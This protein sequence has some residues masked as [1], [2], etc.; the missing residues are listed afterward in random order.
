MEKTVFITV[1]EMAGT[2]ILEVSINERV[3]K[4]RRGET[5]EVPEEVAVVIKRSVKA[6]KDLRRRLQSMRITPNNPFG[7]TI[8]V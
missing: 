8:E 7:K 3:W 6:D 2:E 4:L 5:A 1:P